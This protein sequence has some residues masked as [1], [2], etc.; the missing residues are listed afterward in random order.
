M[1]EPL[2]NK[3]GIQLEMVTLYHIQVVQVLHIYF[4]LFKPAPNM[5]D[6]IVLCMAAVMYGV[7]NNWL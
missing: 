5:C 7:W 6:A 2:P 4:I 1:I 3:I